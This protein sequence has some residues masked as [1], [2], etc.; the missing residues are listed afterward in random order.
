[1]YGDGNVRLYDMCCRRPPATPMI[2]NIGH[3]FNIKL[4]QG[5][6]CFVSAARQL[7]CRIFNLCYRH[8]ATGTCC[9]Q[10]LPHLLLLFVYK[11]WLRVEFVFGQMSIEC[12]YFNTLC[13]VSVYTVQ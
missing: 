8:Q 10:F 11:L 6:Q 1:M 5:S 3:Y 13:C 12:K 2:E 4:R 7:V 9:S